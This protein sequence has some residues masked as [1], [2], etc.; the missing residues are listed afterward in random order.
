SLA[1][2]GIGFDTLGRITIDKSRLTEA[3][4]EAP[5]E[6]ARL[7]A[8]DGA[9]G[10]RFVALED[11]ISTYTQAGGLV[12]DVRQRIGT[13]VSQLAARI[14]VLEEQLALRRAALQAEFI[15]A[16]RAMSQLNS[17]SS[18]LMQ[19]AGQFRLF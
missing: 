1:E 3:L 19:L 4:D 16:D 9:S 6:V 12:A 11:L 17:Q 15:A 2:V 5:L 18:S 14:S 10:G 7:F 13:Q 8:G